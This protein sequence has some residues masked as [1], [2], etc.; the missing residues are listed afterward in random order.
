LAVQPA[1]RW[2][3]AAVGYF[4]LARLSAQAGFVRD[5]VP[6]IVFAPGIAYAAVQLRGP[7][8]ATAVALGG[9]ADGFSERL[10]IGSVLLLAAAAAGAG[11]TAYAVTRS[12]RLRPDRER[13]KDTLIRTAAATAAGIAAASFTLAANAVD[14]R[15]NMPGTDWLLLVLANTAG[16]I[17]VAPFVRAWVQRVATG[18]A[19]VVERIALLAAVL[20]VSLIVDSG[21]LGADAGP[22]AYI[23][24]SVVIWAAL[25]TGRMGMSVV[26][27]SS[28]LI[29][30]KF[31]SAG[32][33]PFIGKDLPRTAVSLNVFLIVLGLTGLILVG[34]E[35]ARR[36]TETGLTEA[37][38]RHRTFL[39][40]L[41]LV[42][43][44]RSLTD[45]NLPPLF[46]SAQTEK[47]LGY[48][49]ERWLAEPRFASTLV[50]PDDREF[51]AELNARSLVE[52]DVQGEYRMIRADGRTVWV[53]DHM[54][55]MRN[56][57]GVP[58][59]QQ[60][61]VVDISER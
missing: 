15:A 39:E 33:G 14:G 24:V 28:A 3:A 51:N 16:I 41:P 36:Q 19:G 54:V 11:L 58:V 48:P 4:A 12:A 53:L 23:V 26:V 6:L 57:A 7:W 40:H 13:L 27:L 37:D 45:L 55:V 50:H 17:V 21:V 43:Y 47:L 8:L 2:L 46:Q 25:R 56:A 20:A 5:G 30:A 44:L 38:E 18:V 29:A 49:V 35:E 32:K 9:A 10:P 61:F 31:T 22:T 34:L 59:A 1:L 42:T 52:D 60:G